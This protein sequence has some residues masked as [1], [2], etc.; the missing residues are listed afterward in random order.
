MPIPKKDFSGKVLLS[1]GY[2]SKAG[3]YTQ[4]DLDEV[5]LFDYYD[6][7]EI[8][9]NDDKIEIF[10]SFRGTYEEVELIECKIKSNQLNIDGKL[11]TYIE[12]DD[13][14]MSLDLDTH[15]EFVRIHAIY[16]TCESCE[17]KD[18]KTISLRDGVLLS[19]PSG[20][21]AKKAEC[22]IPYCFNEK[23]MCYSCIYE[24]CQ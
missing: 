4:K 9:K 16:D 2:C 12:E 24:R 10:N 5:D 21:G 1:Y 14:F 8:I 15:N 20:D 18:D 17:D 11:Y 19:A 13:V 7:N 23:W 3:Q 6:K 22:I